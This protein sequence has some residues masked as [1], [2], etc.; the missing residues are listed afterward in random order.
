MLMCSPH[1]HR[2]FGSFLPRMHSLPSP[3]VLMLR[4]C[5]LLDPLQDREHLLMPRKQRF[6]CGILLISPTRVRV[7]ADNEKDRPPGPPQRSPGDTPT[8]NR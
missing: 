4:W 2:V 1:R 8:E 7:T 5:L 6:T 3:E